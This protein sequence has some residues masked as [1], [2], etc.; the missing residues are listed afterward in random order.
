MSPQPTS[1]KNIK[2]IFYRAIPESRASFALE[3]GPSYQ[4]SNR[5]NVP[6]SFGALYFADKPEVCR[7][8]IEKR[9]F[10]H[11]RIQPHVLLCFEIDCEG[12]LDLSNHQLQKI[13]GININD[14]LKSAEIPGAYDAPQKF[15]LDMYL[16]PKISGFLVPDVT[17]T[18]NTLVLFPAKLLSNKSIRMVQVETL[19]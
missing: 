15:S 2:G 19:N 5:Y 3:D 13:L 14:F 12:V 4:Y 18:G 9:G 6:N 1:F 17:N 7:A 16:K 11:N 10:L 8:T